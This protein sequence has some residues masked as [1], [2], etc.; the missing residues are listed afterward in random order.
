MNRVK[1]AMFATLFALLIA[2]PV[3][4]GQ[5][6]AERIYKPGERVLD[7]FVSSTED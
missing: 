6:E 3:R 5:H 4:R 7:A 1:G 2:M